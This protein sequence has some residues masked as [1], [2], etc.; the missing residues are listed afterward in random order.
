MATKRK[1][2]STSKKP[3]KQ[4]PR[5]AGPVAPGRATSSKATSAPRPAG[6]KSPAP[7][8]AAPARGAAKAPVA[9][10]AAP[11]PV[12]AGVRPPAPKPAAVSPAAGPP[13]PA[14]G[15]PGPSLLERAERL[16]DEVNRSKL[17][18]P[19]PW[20]FA[21]K[22]RGWA[23]RAQA[24]VEQVAAGGDTAES[25]RA[26]DALAAEVERDRDFQEARKLF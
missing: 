25:R 24:L 18:H 1:K 20:A 19:D 22:A 4:T 26:V 7:K 10:A 3:A 14:A 11:R 5:T 6:Q 8:A 2:S 13:H 17:T 21:A 12:A 16:R 23:Q 15:A 9:P